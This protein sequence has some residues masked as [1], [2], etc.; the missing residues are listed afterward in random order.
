MGS[1]YSKASSSSG[2]NIKKGGTYTYN[3]NGINL[4][5]KVLDIKGNDILI[6][7]TGIGPG[8]AEFNDNRIVVN[9]N[10]EVIKGMEKK[11]N[12]TRREAY[13]NWQNETEKVNKQE[14][15]RIRELRSQGM[16][17]QQAVEKADK[18]FQKK[19]DAVDKK[20]RNKRS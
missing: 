11:T 13:K 14:R 17:T 19:R 1:G 7:E 5:I 18:E 15:A 20:Y 8:G 10:A 9:K 4:S 6:S 16:S 12:A 2:T 3:K